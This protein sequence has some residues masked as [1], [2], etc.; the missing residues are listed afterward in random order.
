VA[1]AEFTLRAYRDVKLS[2][3]I[4]NEEPDKRRWWNRPSD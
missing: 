3:L 4:E 1:Q 2:D